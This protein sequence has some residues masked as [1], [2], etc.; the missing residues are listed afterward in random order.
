MMMKR[1]KRA[2]EIHC[3]CARLFDE[4]LCKEYA[5]LAEIV[6]VTPSPSEKFLIKNERIRKEPVEQELAEEVEEEGDDGGYRS[7]RS[8]SCFAKCSQ[9]TARKLSEKF[10][11]YVPGTHALPFMQP[12]TETSSTVDEPLTKKPLACGTPKSH[13]CNSLCF[14][15]IKGPNDDICSKAA[16]E[17]DVSSSSSSTTTT[18]TTP[19]KSNPYNEKTGL[20]EASQV[21]TFWGFPQSSNSF[22][23]ENAV[24]CLLFLEMFMTQ[25][26]NSVQLLEQSW[27]VKSK[28]FKNEAT[29]IEF[30]E[31]KNIDLKFAEV[32]QK[33]PCTQRYLHEF[34]DAA[35]H[36]W[37][38]N[39][40]FDA[41][42]DLI[43]RLLVI[44]CYLKQKI[45]ILKKAKGVKV[46]KTCFCE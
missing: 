8:R 6:V 13:S 26:K 15:S 17:S 35:L 32:C 2:R 34:V 16:S 25:L 7:F 30:M 1:E 45:K 3:H 5:P 33:F 44:V 39:T 18:P 4:D 21:C 14:T 11:V 12:T 41:K 29:R 40:V 28:F 38:E 24:D 10:S 37:D 22:I 9:A 27:N 43:I 36:V 23:T 19:R 31:K 46:D 20:E 42:W